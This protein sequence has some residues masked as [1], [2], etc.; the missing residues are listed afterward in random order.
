MLPVLQIGPFAIQTSGL[1]LL[2]AAWIGLSVAERYA[3]RY[4]LNPNDLYNLAIIAILAGV[5]GARLTYAVRFSG[6]FLANPP[7][8]FSLNPGLLDPTGG[9]AAAVLAGLVYGQRKKLPLLPTLD[10]LT[11]TFAIMMIALA[12]SH[13]ATG[14]AYGSPSNLPWSLTLWGAQRHPSQIYEI[15]AGLIILWLIWPGSNRFGAYFPGKVFLSFLALTAGARLLLEAFRGDS[16]L[17]PNGLRT[18]QVL[19][20]II[21]GAS[22]VAIYRLRPHSDK[23]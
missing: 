13:L 22:L 15:V 8:L 7:S 3:P 4:G 10:A 1:I 20:W 12:L 17:L 23:Q 14:S 19:A 11:P 9:V 2:A 16:A 6:A 5:I 21:L 18:A